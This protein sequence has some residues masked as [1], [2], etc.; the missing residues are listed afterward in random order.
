MKLIRDLRD[1][2]QAPA[3]TV[4]TIGNFDGVHLGHRE[5]FRKVVRKARAMHGTAAVLT[6]EPH[7]LRFLAPDK[8]PPR[9]NTPPEKVRLLEASCIDLL[10]ILEFNQRF[11]DLPAEA[12][13]RDI[14]VDKLAVAEL[15]VGY[16]YA[17]GKNREGDL[18]FLQAK[19]EQY[20]FRL[21][22][23]GPIRQ[24]GEVYSSTRIRQALQAGEVAGVVKVL[25]RHFTL[26]GRVV[27]GAGRG[28]N[29]GFPTA[30][31]ET[32]KELVPAEGVYA[33]KVKWRDRLY[34]AV[35]NIGTCPTFAGQKPTLEIHLIDFR[36]SLY[37]ET[38]RL[39]FVE[40]LRAE[41]RFPSPAAL[42][43]AIRSDVER[44]RTLLET[45][46]VVEYREYLASD[47]PGDPFPCGL[48]E[49]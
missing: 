19:A 25:G 2:H 40:R 18:D 42:V 48:G 21:E 8:A 14:L 29:L 43:T 10:L 34:D 23:L 33:V 16:D 1:I 37:G 32:D 12:F 26:D 46:D 39:Y 27:H 17:F 24:G 30:N 22:T 45:R 44:A 38:L 4:L 9:I 5:I 3:Q 47:R 13:V 28:R 6:F 20:G 31:L 35:V 49:N 41:Q 11:A 15:V 36:Q 7:P